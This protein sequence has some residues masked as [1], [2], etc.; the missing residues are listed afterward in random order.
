MALFKALLAK[1]M[2]PDVLV[3]YTLPVTSVSFVLVIVPSV[4]FVLLVD[5]F[6]MHFAIA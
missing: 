4:L 5:K 3:S 2:H 1:R 6:S